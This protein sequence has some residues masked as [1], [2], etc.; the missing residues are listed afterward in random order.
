MIY[1]STIPVGFNRD[2]LNLDE[3]F[4]YPMNILEILYI[5]HIPYISQYISQGS[6][7]TCVVMSY[8]RGKVRRH[9]PSVAV[10]QVQKSVR[11]VVAMR[12][13]QLVGTGT[14]LDYF[15]Y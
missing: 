2:S 3:Y 1:L 13:V 12:G 15:P 5:L 10:P 8:Q 4:L 11:S 6:L 7:W 9:R 14:W